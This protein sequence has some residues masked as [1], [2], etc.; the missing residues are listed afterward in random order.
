MGVPFYIEPLMEEP[1]GSMEPISTFSIEEKLRN[2]DILGVPW[3]VCLRCVDGKSNKYWEAVGNYGRVFIHWGRVGT[4]GQ[5]I[6]KDIRYVK[7]TMANKLSKGYSF[8]RD[9]PASSD[10]TFKN[11]PPEMLILFEQLATTPV[12]SSAAVERPTVPKPD[13]TMMML[14]PRA[15]KGPEQTP[16]GMEGA[17]TLMKKLDQQKIDFILEASREAMDKAKQRE[18]KPTKEELLRASIDRRKKESE[19]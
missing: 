7:I 19:W 10:A 1:V 18:K 12:A 4:K 15:A 13:G 9:N 16:V 3:R 14:L 5:C 17:S 8:W 11:L 6:E 2:L